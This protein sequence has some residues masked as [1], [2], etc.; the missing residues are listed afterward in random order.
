MTQRISVKSK[1][2]DN[3]ARRFRPDARHARMPS[4]AAPLDESEE[5]GERMDARVLKTVGNGGLEPA[6]DKMVTLRRLD[7][8][9]CHAGERADQTPAPPRI[10]RGTP[11]CARRVVER[12]CGPRS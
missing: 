7:Q 3:A 9:G 2:V 5:V 1:P 12:T 11:A 4:V 6:R 10:P 8:T